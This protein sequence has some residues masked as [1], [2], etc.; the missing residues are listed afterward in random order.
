MIIRFNFNVNIPGT[1]APAATG[2]HHDDVVAAGAALL[3]AGAT[4]RVSHWDQLSVS[5]LE[6]LNLHL[7]LKIV[8]I[9][10]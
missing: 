1:R 2:D 3:V 7:L 9:T 4:R 5:I 10:N 6:L 8:K